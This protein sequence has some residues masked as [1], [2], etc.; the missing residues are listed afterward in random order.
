LLERV[1]GLSVQDAYER[2]KESFDEEDCSFL[3]ENPPKQLIAIQGSLWGV[4][5]KTAKKII[6]F[7]LD[8]SGSGTRVVCVSKL[9]SGW[10]NITLIGC[11]LAALLLGLCVWMAVDLSVFMS[12]NNPSVW[13]WLV[14]DSGNVNVLAE[15]A[16]INL[17]WGMSVFLLIVI[18]LEVAIVVY[19]KS[20]I[21]SF[22][23][24][25]LDSLR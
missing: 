12:T 9:A 7:D 14:S 24:L 22:A 13:S 25:I 8:P 10:K 23:A 3:V 1:V 6:K 17:A 5:P 19:V 2:I 11:V 4:S 15:R 18:I 21:D 20:R 16:F